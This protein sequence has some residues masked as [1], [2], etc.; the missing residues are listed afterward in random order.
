VIGAGIAVLYHM[1]RF[2]SLPVRALAV[3]ALA[4]TPVLSVLP[5]RY[6]ALFP[7][8]GAPEKPNAEWKRQDTD[9]AKDLKERYHLRASSPERVGRRAYKAGSE[10]LLEPP[11]KRDADQKQLAIDDLD[12]AHKELDLARDGMAAGE[13]YPTES[14]E[15]GRQGIISY[16]KAMAVLCEQTAKALRNDAVPGEVED[17]TVDAQVGKVNRLYNA[18][19]K[20]L[21]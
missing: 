19:K 11:D 2:G 12:R 13:P 16:L 1:Q 10:L 3:V 21:P 6:P 9:D 17:K 14:V 5:L 18:C 8:R 20:W 15:E 7:S 4:A